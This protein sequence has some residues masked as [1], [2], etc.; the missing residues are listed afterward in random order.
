MPFSCSNS[1]LVVSSKYYD[2]VDYLPEDLNTNIPYSYLGHFNS[3]V[4]PAYFR[5]TVVRLY[6]SAIE[7]TEMV[8]GYALVCAH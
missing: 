4:A 7:G 3:S 5:L 8:S 6:A 1:S 2:K